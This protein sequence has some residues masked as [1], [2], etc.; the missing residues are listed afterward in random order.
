[1]GDTPQELLPGGLVVECRLLWESDPRPRGLQPV[2]SHTEVNNL[3]VQGRGRLTHCRINEAA[4]TLRLMH[5]DVN[6][7][8]IPCVQ[9]HCST[10]C[11]DVKCNCAAGSPSHVWRRQPR[12]PNDLELML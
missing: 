10:T 11:S 1:M 5:V 9:V 7:K 4:V 3:L 6:S 2:Q 8:S 12:A